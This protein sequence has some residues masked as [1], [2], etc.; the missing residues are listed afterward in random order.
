MLYIAFDLAEIYFER[1]KHARCMKTRHDKLH[2][3][4][5]I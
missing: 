1:M 2:T 5:V 4:G 3:S